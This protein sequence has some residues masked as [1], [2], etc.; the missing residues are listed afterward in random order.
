[1]IFNDEHKD[2][3]EPDSVYGWTSLLAGSEE[4]SI[5]LVLKQDEIFVVGDHRNESVDSRFYGPVDAKD[6]VGYVVI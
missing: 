4:F 1:M 6:I 3:Y 2:G 5:D